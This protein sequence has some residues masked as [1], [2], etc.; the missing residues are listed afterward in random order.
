MSARL[1]SLAC[2]KAFHFT[3]SLYTSLAL[4]W[5]LGVAYH[6]MAGMRKVAETLTRLVIRPYTLAI[7][8][9]VFLAACGAQVASTPVEPEA[10]PLPALE[11][12]NQGGQ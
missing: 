8:S 4:S 11:Q 10:D 1:R 3:S 6:E 12:A 7:F 2:A 5:W 9:I